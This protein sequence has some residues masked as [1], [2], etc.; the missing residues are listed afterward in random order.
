MSKLNKFDKFIGW[1]SPT[2]LEKRALSRAKVELINRQYDAAKSFSGSK[3]VKNSKSA[4]AEI[5]FQLAPIR[6]NVRDLVRNN[7]FA[8]KAVNTICNNTVGWGI[9]PKITHQDKTKQQKIREMWR[10]WSSNCSI[11]GSD[12]NHLQ[13]KVLN[14]VVVDGESIVKEVVLDGSLKLQLLEIDHL[15]SKADGFKD[16]KTGMNVIQGVAVDQYY[17]PQAYF[18][19]DHHPWDDSS[20]SN[21]INASE[22]IHV[23]DK[24]RPNQVRGVSW[25][26]PVAHP[27]KMLSELQFTQLLR[28][29]LSASI[30]G[31]ITQEQSQLPPDQ[32]VAQRE[33]ELELSMGTF[34]YLNPGEKVEF[35]STPNPDGFSGSVKLTLQEIASGLGVTYE[36]LS[37]D[38][39]N[40]NFSSGRMGHIEFQRNIDNWQWHLMIPKFCN[41]A[42]EKFKKYCS[43]KGVD[44]SGIQVT[45]NPPHRTMVNP[46][47]EIATT[48]DAIRAGLQT[49]SGAL[50]QQG[51]DPEEHLNEIKESNEVLDKLGLVLDSDPRKVGNGQLQSG[52]NLVLIKEALKKEGQ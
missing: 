33:E 32:L 41:P 4:N 15:D 51:L 10:E 22:V 11:D 40:V 2:S 46:K 29:K 19:F 31:L 6:E 42:F 45:W 13:R 5:K 27:L 34:R 50:R 7:S 49:L 38:F 30:T 20:N 16:N 39:S 47:E 36:A 52:E 24:L 25:L 8:V 17:R 37:G 28:L 1:F 43:L 9:E 12:F 35:P 18:L 14:S 26:A 48:K 3:I 44:V 21:P 23:F